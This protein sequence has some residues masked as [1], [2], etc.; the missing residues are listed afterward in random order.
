[1][2]DFFKVTKRMV[3]QKAIRIYG[4]ACAELREA[5]C[6]CSRR[7][8][9]ERKDAKIKAWLEVLELINGMIEEE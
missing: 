9:L 2:E 4:D 6:D 7:E 3:L 1:M 8:V 5:Q